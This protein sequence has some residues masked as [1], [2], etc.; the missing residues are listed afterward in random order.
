MKAKSLVLDTQRFWSPDT[1]SPPLSLP[2]TSR[3]GNNGV[4]AHGGG[5]ASDPVWTR[6]PSGIWVLDLDGSEEQY[7]DCGNDHSLNLG[8]TDFTV[9]CWARFPAV[10]NV[11]QFICKSDVGSNNYWEF[12]K[13]APGEIEF[14]SVT[15][16]DGMICEIMGASNINDGIFHHIVCLA[17][18]GNRG[19]IYLDGVDD[20]D[21]IHDTCNAPNMDNP[22]N[23][24]VGTMTN[25]FYT[26]GELNLI[27]IH[28][29]LLS[30]AEVNKHFEAERYFFGV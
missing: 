14:Y 27:R 20:S 17:D 4:F 10:A 2:D 6:L 8:T 28:K 22:S 24:L 29:Y 3:F 18:R 25:N 21:G 19:W 12:M 23:L 16:A 26:T 7:V 5:G 11:A 1:V 9:E 30:P 13:V 15:V